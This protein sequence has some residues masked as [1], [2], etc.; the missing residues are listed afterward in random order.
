M[1]KKQTQTGKVTKVREKS[2]E[3]QEYLVILHNDNVT[4]MDFVVMI[5]MKIFRKSESEATRIMLE[6]HI[7]GKG[8]AGRYTYDIAQTK[9]TQAIRLARANR[10]PLRLTVEPDK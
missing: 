8:V 6:V 9:A 10:F 7:K 5:L 3:P 4:T 1:E 2:H